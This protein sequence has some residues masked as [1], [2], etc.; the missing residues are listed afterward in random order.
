[1]GKLRW[2]TTVL[3]TT[4]I[5]LLLA[6]LVEIL[7]Q[8]KIVELPGL[9]HRALARVVIGTSF[10]MM[11]MIGYTIGIIIISLLENIIAGNSSATPIASQ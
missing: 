7:Q 1:M 11:Y 10:S 3:N 2:D 6:Y 9:Q 5:T 4:L 8:F